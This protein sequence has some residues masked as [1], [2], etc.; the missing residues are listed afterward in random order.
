MF[1]ERPLFWQSWAKMSLARG[2]LA[3]ANRHA[4]A[5]AEKAM[6]LEK[7][8]V[9]YGES[10]GDGMIRVTAANA[11]SLTLFTNPMP[12][13]MP[14][15]LGA[16]IHSMRSALDTA[17]STLMT[18]ATGKDDSRTNFPMHQTERELRASFGPGA[19]TCAD[20]GKTRANRGLNADIR[21][22][23]PDLETLI[24]ESF[25][26]WKEGNPLLWG[27]GKMDNINK[28]KMLLPTFGWT[29]WTGSFVARYKAGGITAFDQTTWKIGPGESLTLIKEAESIEISDPGKFAVEFVFAG[30]NPFTNLE[31]FKTLQEC[32]ALVDG[33]IETLETHFKRGEPT[34]T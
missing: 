28:H 14:L 11:Y 24:M 27:L 33:V 10:A 6:K 23:L 21:D 5:Y 1:D 30:I 34:S 4:T 31:I 20:C 22:H 7:A 9:H 8:N 13:E 17:V 32:V 12:I 25:R 29:R 15:M 3:E 19:R 2:M 16:A 26:P 18:N